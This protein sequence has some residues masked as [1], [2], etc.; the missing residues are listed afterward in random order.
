M[1]PCVEILKILTSVSEED[2]LLNFAEKHLWAILSWAVLC[3][4]AF[5]LSMFPKVFGIWL[6]VVKHVPKNVEK[7]RQ[8]VAKR[9]AK[10]VGKL[11]QWR[12]RR[13]MW[14]TFSYSHAKFLVIEKEYF[15]LLLTFKYFILGNRS[16]ILTD[17]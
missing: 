6:H 16:G 2:V 11:F 5:I 13:S 4:C 17:V 1:K 9:E 12:R 15:N 10:W 7:I 8:K 3:H 14:G